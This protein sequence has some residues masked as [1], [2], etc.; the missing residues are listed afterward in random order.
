MALTD[1]IPPGGAVAD[2]PGTSRKQVLQ[3]L[4]DLAQRTL[5]VPSRTVLDAVME[6]ER[7]GST[8]VGDGVAIPHARTSQVDRMC[9]VFARLKTPVDFDAV[10]GRHADLVFLLL[11]PEDSGAEHLKALARVARL[12]RR[13]DIRTALRAAPDSAAVNAILSGAAQTID[14]A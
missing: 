10:D 3:A 1:L 11:A 12:F 8:G 6:R 4:C 9:G 2:L 13:E 5:H 7:L 14:A